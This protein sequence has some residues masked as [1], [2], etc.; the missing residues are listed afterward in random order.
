MPAVTVALPVILATATAARHHPP[1]TADRCTVGSLCIWTKPG[2]Q[3]RM[4][5]FGDRDANAGA[6]Q[7]AHSAIGSVADLTAKAPWRLHLFLFHNPQAR[8]CDPRGVFAQYTPGQTDGA[9]QGPVTGFRIYADPN[10]GRR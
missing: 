4:T 3:G 5:V 9:V 10:P 7:E 6:C 2:F 1:H 8:A